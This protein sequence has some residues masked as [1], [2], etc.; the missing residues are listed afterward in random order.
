[1][2]FPASAGVQISQWS[3]IMMKPVF[4]R[5]FL[6]AILASSISAVALA[7]PFDDKKMSPTP[8]PAAAD[9]PQGDEMKSQ[10][11]TKMKE[12]KQMMKEGKRKMKKEKQEI[13]KKQMEQM[14]KNEADK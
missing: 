12:E 9:T 5:L 2:S 4:T 3:H 13:K 10:P 8:P 7:A 14:N 11:E 6:L 1:V